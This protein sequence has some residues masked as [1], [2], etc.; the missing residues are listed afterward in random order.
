MYVAEEGRSPTSLHT[1]GGR[2]FMECSSLVSFMIN[3]PL[4]IIAYAFLRC[5]KLEKNIRLSP[6]DVKRLGTVVFTSCDRLIELSNGAGYRSKE[7]SAGEQHVVE[8]KR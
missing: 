3:S 5:D 8:A 6:R 2:S 1:L 7:R 4:T